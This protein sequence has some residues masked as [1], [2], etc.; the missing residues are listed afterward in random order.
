MRK[1]RLIEV[2]LSKV[3]QL[4]TQVPKK[5]KPLF[6]T[7][8][9]LLQHKIIIW[10]LT[11][12]FLKNQSAFWVHQPDKVINEKRLYKNIIHVVFNSAIIETQ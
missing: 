10:K 6:F 3:I 8:V 4:G 7:P 2:N 12:I 5:L 1:L 9:L 11:H